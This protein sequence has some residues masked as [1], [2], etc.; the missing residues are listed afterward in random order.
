MNLK[1]PELV[2]GGECTF[3]SE[4]IQFSKIA[5]YLLFPRF[6]AAAES[7]WLKEENKDFKNFTGR[8]ENHKALLNKLDFLF[9]KGELE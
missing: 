3:W 5:E 6:C 9:Y 1:N 2:I 4:K 8:L 7:M